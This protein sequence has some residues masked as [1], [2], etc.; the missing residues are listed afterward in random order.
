MNPPLGT[1]IERRY[2][3]RLYGAWT[4]L[5]G[6]EESDVWRVETDQGMIVVILGPA[7][8]TEDEL[9]WVHSLTA[10]CS[11][12]IPEVVAPIAARDGSTVFTFA[13]QPVCLFPFIDG[14]ELDTT[15]ES[16]CLS[17][18]RLLARIHTA[19]Q[20]WIG[21]SIPRPPSKPLSPWDITLP[22]D[23]PELVDAELDKWYVSLRDRADVTR[24]A[25]HADYY[26][27]NTLTRDGRICG[28]ID[29]ND[30]DIAPLILEVGWCTW[31]FTQTPTGD[32][33]HDDRARAFLTAYVEAGGPCPP[34]E[35]ASAVQAIRWR[36]RN[37]SRYELAAA[38]RGEDWDQEYTEQQIRAFA[39]LRGRRIWQ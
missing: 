5:A 9:R 7:W 29:W 2:G 18:A 21:S 20:T 26:S 14:A 3:R 8:R 13:D 11:R 25:V 39:Q 4:R 23:P 27:R 30:S 31:E 1:E 22:P 6:G 37:E 10:H 34:S 15:D 28:V 32:E 33:L 12:T 17:A 35:F 19:G 36:L 38:A 24:G 16:L